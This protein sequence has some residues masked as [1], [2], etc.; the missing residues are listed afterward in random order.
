MSDR[1]SSDLSVGSGSDSDNSGVDGTGDTVVQLVV[2]LWDWV[3]VVDGGFGKISHGSG[4]NHVSDGHSLDGLVL[5][6]ASGTVDTSDW[7]DVTSTVL[8]S[9]VSSSLLWHCCFYLGPK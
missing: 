7:L 9:T 2:H 3:F 6:N 1:R 4:F 5:W 8:V